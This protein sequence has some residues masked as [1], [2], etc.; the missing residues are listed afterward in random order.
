MEERMAVERW[1]TEPGVSPEQIA[2][3][4]RATEEL[5][6]MEEMDRQSMRAEREYLFTSPSITEQMSVPLSSLPAVDIPPLSAP[7]QCNIM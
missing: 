3:S 1:A 7:E 5:Y 2:Q 6:Q 4:L